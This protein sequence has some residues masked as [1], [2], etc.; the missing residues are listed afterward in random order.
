[1]RKRG[2]VQG[3]L[4]LE[5]G[6]EAVSTSDLIGCV[7]PVQALWSWLDPQS[8][9][10][11]IRDDQ[12]SFFQLP[13]RSSPRSTQRRHEDGATNSPEQSQWPAAM[14]ITSHVEDGPWQVQASIKTQHL[15][16]YHGHRLVSVWGP[17]GS[18]IDMVLVLDFVSIH[19]FRAE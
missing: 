7:G 19:I 18:I 6:S 15:N 11:R 12:S 3:V 10:Y 16:V 8:S 4:L 17:P 13:R 9:P 14:H 5:V 1:M 2:C